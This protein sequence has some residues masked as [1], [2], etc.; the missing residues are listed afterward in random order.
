MAMCDETWRISSG[1]E[2]RALNI[3][4]KGGFGGRR[5]GRGRD[6][7]GREGGKT[8]GGKPFAEPRFVG[9]RFETCRRRGRFVGEGGSRGEEDGRSFGALRRRRLTTLPTGVIGQFGRAARGSS[10]TSIMSS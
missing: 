2:S 7:G 3:P 8:C 10:S 6:G 4:G 1:C 9:R 5:D